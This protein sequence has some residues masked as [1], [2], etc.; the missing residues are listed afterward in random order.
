VQKGNEAEIERAAARFVTLYLDHS[1]IDPAWRPLLEKLNSDRDAVVVIATDHYAE[2][3]KMIIDCLEEWGIKALNA[4]HVSGRSGSSAVSVANSSDS[5]CLKTDRRFWETLKEKLPV[6][7]FESV[8]V[9]DDFGFNEAAEDDYGESA[10]VTERRRETEAL[11][12]DV[13]QTKIEVIPFFLSGDEEGDKDSRI[14][15]V[16]GMI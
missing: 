2:A 9:V 14:R 16:T 8:F 3:T 4:K 5:G 7:R 11:L 13:F 10:R 12:R 6:D 15:E 1:R